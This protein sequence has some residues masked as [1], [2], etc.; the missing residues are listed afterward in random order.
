MG[1]AAVRNVKTAAL[2]L[3]VR[4]IFT[5]G[6]L[7][8]CTSAGISGFSIAQAALYPEQFGPWGMNSGQFLFMAVLGLMV[9][10]VA[11]LTTCAGSVAALWVEAA[12]SSSDILPRTLTAGL[13]AGVMTGVYTV[14]VFQ[15]LGA[16]GLA[17]AGFGAGFAAA[18]GLLAAFFTRRL[19]RRYST[20]RM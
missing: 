5:G 20:G 4:A 7:G 8:A 19:V 14:I 9:G 11:G 3:F 17:L 1:L 12:A 15:V 13:G 16:A 18:S 6:L 2:P 10:A